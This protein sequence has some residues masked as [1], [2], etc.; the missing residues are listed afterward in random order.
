MHHGGRFCDLPE[1]VAGR[2]PGRESTAEIIV[3]IALGIL[4]EYAAILPEVYRRAV[5]MG[6]GQSLPNSQVAAGSQQ[7]SL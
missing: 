1:I 3:Y 2:L 6:L 7:M 4:G 5:S